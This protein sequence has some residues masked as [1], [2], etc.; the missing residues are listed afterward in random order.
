MS[1]QLIRNLGID[2]SQALQ[3][4][5]FLLGR[6]FVLLDTE[7]TGLYHDA[8]IV[9]LGLLGS[10]G[11][12]PISS[13][14]KPR[15]PIPE[16]ATAIHGITNEMVA[17]APLWP[18]VLEQLIIHTEG[19]PIVIYNAQFDV[20]ML[21]QTNALYLSNF[22][23]LMGSQG[24]LCAM[25]EYSAHRMIVNPMRR[26]TRWWKLG[27]AALAEGVTPGEAHRAVGDCHTTLGVIRAVQNKLAP[28][29]EA[30]GCTG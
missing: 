14:V 29:W 19:K 22:P 27:E 25:L 26:S 16:G 7:T 15:L 20:R 28:L 9:E 8:E 10:D 30:E 23:T 24:F 18:E 17:D 21:E 13:L 1:S 5:R 4:F 2:E 11:T 12:E 6:D 3:A